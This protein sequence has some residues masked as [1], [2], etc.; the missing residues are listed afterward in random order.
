MALSRNTDERFYKTKAWR[1][2]RKAYGQS[3]AWLCEDCLEQGRI[4]S[5]VYVHH[6]IP[7]DRVN[8]EDPRISL[9]HENL[10][11]LCMKCHNETHYGKKKDLNYRFQDDGTIVEAPLTSK[12]KSV[13]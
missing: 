9:N 4:T 2:C 11:L 12:I 6:V 8:V 1:D 3:K 5:G 13:L 10:R 7:L